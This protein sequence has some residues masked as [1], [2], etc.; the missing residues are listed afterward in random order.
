MDG[1]QF[2]P[3]HTLNS[4]TWEILTNILT[5]LDKT[6]EH[7]STQLKN[8]PKK[9]TTKPALSQGV[10]ARASVMVETQES[11]SGHVYYLQ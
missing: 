9:S 10:I 5:S 11:R 3:I 8:K 7:P 6:Q 2:M 1:L 4:N